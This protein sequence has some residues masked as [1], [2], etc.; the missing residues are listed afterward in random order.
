MTSPVF[1]PTMNVITNVTNGVNPTVTTLTNHGYLAGNTVFINIP[2]TYGMR[3]AYQD[4]EI[5][6]ITGL[7]TFTIKTD[8]TMA[9]PFII[10][11]L[12]SFTP[13]QVCPVTQLKENI[14]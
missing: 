13:A 4:F 8:T 6:D 1:V 3:I 11:G 5:I 12:I 14:A 7:N 2:D 9:D 10:P